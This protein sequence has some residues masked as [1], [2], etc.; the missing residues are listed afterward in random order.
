MLAGY[1][2]EAMHTRRH[3]AIATAIL[4]GTLFTGPA[5]AQQAQAP[6]ASALPKPP[7]Q[8]TVA[9]VI[10]A[11]RRE[12]LASWKKTGDWPRTEPDFAAEKN[13]T[14]ADKQIVQALTRKLNPNP[15]I[16]GYVKWQLLGFGPDLTDLDGNTMNRVFAMTPPPLSPPIPSVRNSGNNNATLVFGRQ[17]AYIA[18]LDPVVGNGVAAYNPVVGVVG[19][20]TSF[21]V[22]AY[23]E[24]RRTI[25]KANNKIT[26]GRRVARV[27]NQAIHAYRNNL[28]RML[29]TARGVRLNMMLRDARD[30]LA[31]GDE[32][33]HNVME[34][35]I[36][37]AP[38]LIADPS[39]TPK[40][41]AG[42]R[43]A[44]DELGRLRKPVVTSL[45][46]DDRGGVIYNKQYVAP[47]PGD[48]DLLSQQV[49]APPAVSP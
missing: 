25:I 36:E 42:I 28:T 22:E 43:E 16:D 40:Q 24:I 34:S 10:G 2:S 45:D 33:V 15:A 47:R 23:A 30:R 27:A 31:A 46:L 1:W 11:L 6:D 44:V 12:A 7:R 32:T 29:P 9:V 38:K 26:Q 39:I 41:H 8:T 19:S 21:G 49:H 3:S 14:V 4:I 13:W 48:V 5:R 37:Q 18:D 35:L 17:T 20:G